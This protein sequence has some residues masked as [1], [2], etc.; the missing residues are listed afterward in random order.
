LSVNL[1]QHCD[2]RYFDGVPC[3]SIRLGTDATLAENVVR[4][5]LRQVYGYE[6]LSGFEYELY[7]EGPVKE[8][9]QEASKSDVKK[10]PERDGSIQ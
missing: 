7:D 1:L 8:Q 9:T 6:S 3:F 10:S 4:S 2:K 5:V